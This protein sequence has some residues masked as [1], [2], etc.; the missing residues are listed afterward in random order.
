[1]KRIQGV[2]VLVGVLM[3]LCA[4]VAYAADPFP[5]MEIPGIDY[6]R[7][8]CMWRIN[9]SFDG[10]LSGDLWREYECRTGPTGISRTQIAFRVLSNGGEEG[11]CDQEVHGIPPNMYLESFGMTIHRKDDL[12]HYSGRVQLKDG[13]LGPVLFEG[14]MELMARIGT[15]Q[16]LGER[17][18]EEKHIE[19]WIVARGVDTLSNFTFRAMVAGEATLP[20]GLA[21][22]P[23]LNRITGVIIESN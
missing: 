3:T 22:T 18:D 12:A 1:M 5:P 14:T 23:P 8:L 6:N 20:N 21:A 7:K 4:G 9:K 10:V 13:A 15:H 19:G 16:A 11:T 2:A 17:C